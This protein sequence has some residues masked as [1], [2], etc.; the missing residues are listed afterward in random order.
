M[1]RWRTALEEWRNRISARPNFEKMLDVMQHWG[2]R[3]LAGNLCFVEACDFEDFE[4]RVS[5]CNEVKN[6][7]K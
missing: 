1:E 7:K 3:W 4:F 2:S 5:H 6:E